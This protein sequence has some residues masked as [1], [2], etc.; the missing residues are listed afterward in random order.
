MSFIREFGKQ[1]FNV[2]DKT[3]VQ[4]LICLVQYKIVN[5][6]QADE[7]LL[8]QIQQTAWSCYQN[9]NTSFQFFSLF[10]LLDTSKNN[11]VFKVRIL[12]VFGKIVVYLNGEFSGRS[13]YQGFD[14]SRAAFC[15]GICV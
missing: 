9:I 13:H 10:S 3:H 4:H 15:A 8:H 1:F 11:R 6:F 12:S 2:M 7:S 5:V 14:F